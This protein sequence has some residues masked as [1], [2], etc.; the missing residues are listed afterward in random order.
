MKLVIMCNVMRL[1]IKSDL[2]FNRCPAL[3]QRHHEWGDEEH[4]V[5]INLTEHCWRDLK[6]MSPIRPDG[7]SDVLE[8]K[9][10]AKR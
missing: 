8:N 6:M 4:T 10:G 5:N 7:A 9:D 3:I 2:V 1:I